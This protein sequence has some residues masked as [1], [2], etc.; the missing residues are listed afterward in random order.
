MAEDK[1]QLILEVARKHFVQKGYAATRMQEIA[2][3]A[4]INKA[5]L[6]YY[7]RSKDKLYHEIMVRILDQVL[8]RFAK[9]LSHEG[10]FWEQVESVV[11]NYIE[12]L[13]EQ[14]DIPFFIMAE[15]SQQQARFVGELQKR[16][17][18]FGAMHGFLQSMMAEMAS[19]RIKQIP[20][21][22]LLLN[23]MGLTV[24]P[25]IAKPIF[26]TIMGVSDKD[27][28]Q[29]MQGRKDVV[30]QFLRDALAPST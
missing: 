19:G 18:H 29:L 27:F 8:P 21:A 15:L 2:D 4:G 26:S 23:I 25:F 20:P 9:A 6:H 10:S 1:E 22:H 12:L 14:P 3:E 28:S 24:F 13:Q 30:M 7:F 17:Q 11:S 5:L 16:S